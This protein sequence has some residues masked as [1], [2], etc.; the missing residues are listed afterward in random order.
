MRKYILAGALLGFAALGLSQVSL[1]QIR[2]VANETG[3]LVIDSTSGLFGIRQVRLGSGLALVGNEIVVTVAPPAVPTPK[4]RSWRPTNGQ[5]RFEIN[6]PLR[7][8]QVYVNG[9]NVSE[10][11][12]TEVSEG[13]FT[14]VL[15]TFY[16][17]LS[18]VDEVLVINF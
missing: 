15:P 10:E 11:A 6:E 16:S 14:V 17:W 2:Q 13:K 8:I 9:L 3:I 7:F 1:R 4:K 18:P 5:L 12:F